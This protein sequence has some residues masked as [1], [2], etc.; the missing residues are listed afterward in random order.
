M[1]G[2]ING[3]LEARVRAEGL[4]PENPNLHGRVVDNDSLVEPLFYLSSR[5]APD[6]LAFIEQLIAGD[7]RFFPL[8]APHMNYNANTLLV[9]AIR[10]G[11][12]GAYWSI[13][14]QLRG[15]APEKSREA[16]SLRAGGA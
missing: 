11:A 8:N 7:S 14:D 4:S 3:A 15:N 9:E 5:I 13:L 6:P 12:R 1:A 10:G 2:H 16:A